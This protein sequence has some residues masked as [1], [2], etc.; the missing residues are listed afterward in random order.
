M[1]RATN[2]AQNNWQSYIQQYNPVNTYYMNT[3]A[4]QVPKPSYYYNIYESKYVLSG[5][6]ASGSV[7]VNSSYNV[8]SESPGLSWVL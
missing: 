5:G 6:E 8:G 3:N 2:Y 4:F 7:W 1:S